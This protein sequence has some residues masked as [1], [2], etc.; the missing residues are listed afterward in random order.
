ML[1][2]G[3]AGVLTL[4]AHQVRQQLGGG[5]KRNRFQLALY[6][7][8]DESWPASSTE[9]RQLKRHAGYSPHSSNVKVISIRAAHRA[10]KK[11]K[12]L[13]A[14]GE[15]A[16]QHLITHGV[17][18]LTPVSAQQPDSASAGARPG[19]A[20]AAAAATAAGNGPAQPPPASGAGEVAG[21]SAAAAA[22]ATAGSH[23][24]F[25]EL[26][27]LNPN[28]LKKLLK[29]SKYGLAT[30]APHLMY[31]EPLVGQFEVSGVERHCW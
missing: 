16:F 13:S 21:S 26:P 11:L 25:S 23:L 19:A 6:S 2:S 30:V 28:Q 27:T 9:E 1:V 20:A 15:A 31:T 29:Q 4:G 12:V 24:P 18:Y 22:A 17:K 10:L 5:V 8:K 14:A 3:E 7:N